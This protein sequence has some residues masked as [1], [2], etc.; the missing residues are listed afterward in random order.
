MRSPVQLWRDLGTRQFVSFQLTVGF[1]TITTLVNPFVWLLT[2]AYLVT[3]PRHIEAL[4]PP[5]TLYA[6]L[7]CMA[8]G[9]LMMIYVFMIGCMERGLHRGVRAM[10]S[11]PVYWALMS[12]AGYKAVLQLLRPGR[13]HYWELTQH[14]LVDDEP[15]LTQP[16]P[17]QWPVRAFAGPASRPTPDVGTDAGLA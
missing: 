3:G 1:F 5:L 7:V 2:L 10:L 8:L 12:I 6:G 16:V 17:L 14:G 13:R 11:V 9:N 4:F 15:E